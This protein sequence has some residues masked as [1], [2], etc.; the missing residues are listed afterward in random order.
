[1][2]QSPPA[3]ITCPDPHDNLVPDRYVVIARRQTCSCCKQTHEWSELYAWVHTKSHL[4]YR[5]ISNLRR[6]DWPRYNVPVQQVPV[7]RD[8][9]VPFC[10]SCHEPSLA[11]NPSMLDPP[12]QTAQVIG[13]APA[14]AKPY[15]TKP[16]TVTKGLDALVELLS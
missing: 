14:P 5:N 16:S 4:G 15:T 3:P 10:H 12:R 9:Q 6:I 8:E 11:H 7:A 13:L 2:N 1:M